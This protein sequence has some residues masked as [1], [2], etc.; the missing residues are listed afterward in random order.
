MVF[1][2]GAAQVQ[3]RSRNQLELEDI[4]FRRTHYKPTLVRSIIIGSLARYLFMVLEL[5]SVVLF[6]LSG[7][8][9][10]RKDG[11]IGVFRKL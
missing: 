7:N 6:R 2:R 11:W 10:G 1:G 5:A 9:F 8:R 4:W 3:Y